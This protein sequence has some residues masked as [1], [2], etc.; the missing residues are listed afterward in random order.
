MVNGPSAK[1]SATPNSAATVIAC[2][3]Q[4]AMIISII[5]A[6]AGINRWLSRYR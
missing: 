5:V 2:D 6:G 4:V 3:T 1:A